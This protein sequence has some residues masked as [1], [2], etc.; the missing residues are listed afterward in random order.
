MVDITPH[1]VLR[2]ALSLKESLEHVGE[3]I[4]CQHDAALANGLCR[5]RIAQFL[6]VCRRSKVVPTATSK[7]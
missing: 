5:S 3:T 4:P 7:P 2:E 6:A 1:G